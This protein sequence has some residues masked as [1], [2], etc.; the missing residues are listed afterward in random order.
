[1]RRLLIR[2]GGIGDCITCFPVMEWLCADYT[3][4]WVPGAVVPLVQFANRARSIASTGLDLVG[5]EGV[6]I[7]EN[8]REKLAGFDEIVSWY[9][10]NRAEFRDAARSLNANWRFLPA[11]P[12]NS[13]IQPVTDFHA[14]QVGAPPGLIPRVR[15]SQTPRRET[16]VIHPFSGG[17]VKNWPLEKFRELA[18]A[19]PLP[20]EWTA[21]AEEELPEAHRF[22][23]L[24]KLAEWI[25]GASL[26]IGNDSGITHLAAAAGVHAIGLYTAA[27]A[28][29]WS[30][31]GEAVHHVVKV[32][33]AEIGA[34]DVLEAAR[35]LLPMS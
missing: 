30:A 27:N 18:R 10:S 31:R 29:V 19:L 15:V 9:G 8:L 3:E 2:P 12:P 6:A 13:A 7:P 32:S 28:P 23:D 21:G 20:V 4:V 34:G 17:R 24:F 35:S 14:S 26:Y 5:L 11:L 16:I 25:A 1:M 22:E 33:L